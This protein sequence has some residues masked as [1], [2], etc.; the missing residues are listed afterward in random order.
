M[1]DENKTLILKELQVIPGV[2]GKTAEDIW[3][4]DI[5]SVADLKGKDPEG[6]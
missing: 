5:R 1:K 6:L 3:E 2:G 4:L